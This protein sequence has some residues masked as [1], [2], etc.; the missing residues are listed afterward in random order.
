MA[1]NR[2]RIIAAGLAGCTAPALSRFARADVTTIRIGKQYGLPYLPQMVMERLKLVEKHAAKSGLPTLSVEWLSLSG[3]GALND[4]LLSGAIEFINV[5]PPSV[6]TL[7]EKTRASPRPVRALCGVQSMP[8]VMVTRNATAKS[9]AELSEKDKIAVPTVKISAQANVLEMAAA[10]LW[11]ADNWAKLDPQTL[12]IGHPD[13]MAALLSGQAEITTHFTVAP[14]YY[15]ELASPGMHAILKSYDVVGGHHSNGVQVT[16][17]PFFKDNP[18]I[19]AAVLAAHEE[20]NAFIHKTPRQAAE[21]YA[22]LA[23]DTR[24]SLDRL[25]TMIADPDVDWTTTPDKM[26]TFTSFLHT[27]GRL[28]TLPSSWKELFLPLVHDLKGS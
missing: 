24:N 14:F 16:T 15:Y 25:T 20:A 3:P 4:A 27:T 2:R 17:E 23:K 12:S 10:K 9:I 7:W 19:C 28:K 13:A 21:I 26:M 22:E 18:K 5:G 8:Y 1:W 6:A 11:G